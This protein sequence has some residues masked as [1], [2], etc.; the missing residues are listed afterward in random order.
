ML[1]NEPLLNEPTLAEI[2]TKERELRG[3]SIGRVIDVPT[4]TIILAA[5]EDPYLVLIGTSNKHDRPVLPGGKIDSADIVGLSL[6]EA[7][8]RAALRELTEELSGVVPEQLQFFMRR[9]SLGEDMRLV[10]A[11]MLRD[12]LVAATVEDYPDDTL[13]HARY[14]SPDFLFLGQVSVGAVGGSSELAMVGF[15]DVRF[16]PANALSASHGAI[17]SDYHRALKI[18][19]WV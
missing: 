16:M 19:I 17:L 1:N 8:K 10:P 6:E 7:A 3:V 18:Q 15:V 5:K 4:A 12:S 2:V 14:G 9:E 13:V 11:R